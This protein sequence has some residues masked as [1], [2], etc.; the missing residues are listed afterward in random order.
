MNVGMNNEGARRVSL[1]I[2]TVA[3]PDAEG[4]LEPVDAPSN[5]KDPIKIQQYIQDKQ[6][7]QVEK[8]ALDLDLARIVAVGIQFEGEEPEVLT[9]QTSDE[10]L[11]LAW[12]WKCIG[13]R[14]TIGFNT[15]GFDIPMC[16]RRSLYLGLQT[17]DINIDRYRTPHIDLQQ[18]LSFDGKFKYRSLDFY[19]RR[20]QLP[21]PDDSVTGADV[22]RLVAENNWAAVADHCESDLRK[23]TALAQRM[24][25]LHTIRVPEA[26][27]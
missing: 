9:A 14:V 8:A 18:K 4:F 10:V 13:Q 3:L 26:V 15:L 23:V 21:V 5:Y 22:A 24:G 1:D 17:P 6:R 19:C 2:E 16:L 27:F 12:L 11:M 7:E 25:Y 20:L